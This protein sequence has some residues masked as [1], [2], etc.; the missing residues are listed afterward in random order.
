MKVDLKIDSK[1]FNGV[2]D[3]VHVS[4]DTVQGLI[5][6]VVLNLVNTQE[7]DDYSFA[8][9]GDC[10]VFGIKGDETIDIYV[11]QNYKHAILI[12]DKDNDT[13]EKLSWSEEIEINKDDIIEDIE[14]IGRELSDIKDSIRK[15][16]FPDREI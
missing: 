3:A 4:L 14:R 2:D 9:T 12:S 6:D 5:D 1:Y 10:F 8:A 7:K 16:Y 15:C 13:W 11:T